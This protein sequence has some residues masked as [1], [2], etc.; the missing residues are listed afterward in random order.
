MQ[1]G[2]NDGAGRNDGLNQFN[3]EGISK[4]TGALDQDQLH[5]LKTVLDGMT[6]PPERLHQLC[7]VHRMMPRAAISSVYKTAETV[8]AADHCSRD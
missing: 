4:L 8:A 6:K 1:V 2:L 7:P 3:E 5:S